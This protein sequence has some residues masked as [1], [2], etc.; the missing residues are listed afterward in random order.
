V[1]TAKDKYN[2]IFKYVARRLQPYT[3]SLITNL[4]EVY[5]IN[6]ASKNLENIDI[7][8]I[9]NNV[10]I[11]QVMANCKSIRDMILYYH[12]TSKPI[13]QKEKN[14]INICNYIIDYNINFA[15]FLLLVLKKSNINFGKHVRS[16]IIYFLTGF[17]NPSMVNYF[18]EFQM[19]DRYLEQL[20]NI[21]EIYRSNTFS[22]N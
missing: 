21:N 12:V 8:N 1:L 18:N 3:Y 17:I 2:I 20:K 4:K 13:G 7:F 10:H 5:F 11:L 15:I 6:V 9:T 22:N 16:I 14:I 19:T